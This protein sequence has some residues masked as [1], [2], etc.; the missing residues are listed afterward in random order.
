[1]PT[2]IENN[3]TALQALKVKAERLPD[4]TS[5][6]QLQEKTVTPSTEVQEVVPDS[7]YDGLSRVTVEGYIDY[8]EDLN[9]LIDRSITQIVV[10][11]GTEVIGSCA[12]SDCKALNNVVL[13]S[14]VT[15][16]GGEAF[17][18][19]P[20]LRYIE[21][22][23]NLI[24]IGGSA[25]RNCAEL[26]LTSLPE[27]VT[28]IEVGA[29][30]NCTKLA[31]TSLPRNLNTVGWSAFDGCTNLAISTLPSGIE[32]IAAGLFAHCI[33]LKIIKIPSTATQLDTGAFD[34]C[35][36]L[37][38]IWISKGCTTISGSKASST[39]FNGCTNLTDIY[40]DATEKLSGWGDYFN[41]TNSDTQATVHYNVTEAEFDAMFNTEYTITW[42]LNNAI[43]EEFLAAAP[44][45]YRG[46][47][48]PITVE[49]YPKR[50]NYRF[51]GWTILGNLG[52]GSGDGTIRAGTY[53][54]LVL[55]AVWTHIGGSS[56]GGGSAGGSSN[57]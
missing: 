36:G 29:F 56:G 25:F 57:Q 16:I 45:S 15:A 35:T 53:G 12:F 46:I 47:D 37:K 23:E 33:N 34:S 51:D 38:K 30:M 28:A 55:V 40:T 24:N 11:E 10:P 14:T 43:D 32:Y 26:A 39:P 21:L 3:T 41:Y 20:K 2:P 8:N 52:Q 44:T 31:L 48:L 54:D 7:G 18:F 19:C 50:E 6:P 17:S 1:M 49:S 4:K 9:G 27:S 22:P 13:P 5:P 42:N